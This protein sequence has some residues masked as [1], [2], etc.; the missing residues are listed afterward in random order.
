MRTGE[1]L[2]SGG[3]RFQAS[4]ETEPTGGTL[5]QCE[6]SPAGAPRVSQASGRA[7]GEHRSRNRPVQAPATSW[8]LR[9][10]GCHYLQVVGT[11]HLRGH[12]TNPEQRSIALQRRQGC[13]S[14]PKTVGPK[15]AGLRT[16]RAALE[17]SR[18]RA[19][20]LTKTGPEWRAG[21]LQHTPLGAGP[22]PGHTGGHVGRLCVSLRIFVAF[23]KF[24]YFQIKN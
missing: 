4:W 2:S 13:L 16:P 18:S 20:R 10:R 19:A 7:P 3:H 5:G 22:V 23:Y 1:G 14:S 9:S 8:S 17:A 6:D 24:S 12:Q 21:R 11:W 15:T